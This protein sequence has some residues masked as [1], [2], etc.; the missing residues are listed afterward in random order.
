MWFSGSSGRRARRVMTN[1]TAL[2]SYVYLC[3]LFISL[4]SEPGAC[5]YMAVK[6]SEAETD[7][8]AGKLPSYLC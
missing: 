6:K 5:V 8:Q 1:M 7:E 2:L 3:D 4:S